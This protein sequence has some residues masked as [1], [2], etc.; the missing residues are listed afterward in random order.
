MIVCLDFDGVLHHRA[1]PWRG[2]DVIEGLPV[3][4]AREAVAELRRSGARVLVHSAR[5]STARGLEAV[6]RW[7]ARSSIEVDQVVAVKPASEVYVDDRA[8]NFRGDWP[9]TLREV[10]EFRPWSGSLWKLNP[11]TPTRRPARPTGRKRK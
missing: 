9:A 3:A 5:C 8:V 4:G 2:A 6:R 10:R 11:A 7:L 1:G